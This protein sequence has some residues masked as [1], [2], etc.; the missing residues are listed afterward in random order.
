MIASRGSVDWRSL[1]TIYG[2][3]QAAAGLSFIPAGIGI[4]EGAIAVAL[5]STGTSGGVAIPAAVTY[6]AISCWLPIAA[7]WI[8][9]PPGPP[10]GSLLKNSRLS[11]RMQLSPES[12]CSRARYDPKAAR[13]G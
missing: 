3:G 1:V 9:P 6:R 10:G 5:I 11:G 2:A 12:A 7:G 4:V 8:V 13:H